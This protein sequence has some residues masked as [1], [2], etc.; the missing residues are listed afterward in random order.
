MFTARS[1]QEKRQNNHN[2][3]RKKNVSKRSAKRKKQRTKRTP[4]TNHERVLGR[5]EEEHLNDSQ[6]SNPDWPRPR[7]KAVPK[8]RKPS[9]HTQTPTHLYSTHLLTLPLPI[10]IPYPLSP[11]HSANI[12]LDDW[13]SL[14]LSFPASVDSIDYGRGGEDVEAVAAA[15]CYWSQEF[16]KL[17]RNVL[18]NDFVCIFHFIEF[19]NGQQLRPGFNLGQDGHTKQEGAG[20]GVEGKIN[21]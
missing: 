21:R 13:V 1:Q 6:H 16:I 10:P 14:L 15:S 20:Q 4:S 11:S 19:A 5:T 17:F 7:L 18:T 9:T 8:L 3:A 2:K 12:V